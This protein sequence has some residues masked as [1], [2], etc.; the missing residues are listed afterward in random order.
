MKVLVDT[1][2]DLAKVLE[3]HWGELHANARVFYIVEPLMERGQTIKFGIAGM[4][5]TQLRKN[6][7]PI[8]I[9]MVMESLSL[10][11][12]VIWFTAVLTL[13][14]QI[15]LLKARLTV[16]GGVSIAL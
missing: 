1:P 12:Q 4:R 11:S 16:P 9:V 15:I 6:L 14:W 5:C 10:I 8:V 2:T 7:G 3:Q 13:S